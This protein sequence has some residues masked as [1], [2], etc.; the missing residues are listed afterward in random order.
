MLIAG[1]AHSQQALEPH[2]AEILDAADKAKLLEGTSTPDLFH[3]SCLNWEN[4]GRITAGQRQRGLGSQ[5]LEV[6]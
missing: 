3:K 2:Q 5:Q 4:E 1:N 6:G